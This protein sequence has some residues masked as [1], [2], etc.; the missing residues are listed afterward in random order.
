MYSYVVGVPISKSYRLTV[1][2]IIYYL[3]YNTISLFIWVS[4]YYSLF[5]YVI[6]FACLN[7]TLGF[8]AFQTNIIDMIILILTHLVM[9]NQSTFTLLTFKCPKCSILLCFNQ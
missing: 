9:C 4:V 6:L 2:I 5:Q 8:S 7:Y 1:I 3:I